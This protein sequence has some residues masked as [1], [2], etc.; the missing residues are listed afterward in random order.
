[1]P[2]LEQQ[3]ENIEAKIRKYG[4]HAHCNVL[5]VSEEARAEAIANKP[6][7]SGRQKTRISLETYSPKA[8]SDWNQMLENLMERCGCNPLI[9]V[10]LLLLFV[11]EAQ[12]NNQVIEVDE[13]GNPTYTKDGIDIAKEALFKVHDYPQALAE[14]KAEKRRLKKARETK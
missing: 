9:V 12:R 10:D 7:A 1:M 5:V 11:M 4:K 2:T 3:R 6:D 8:Y 14:A 13:Y